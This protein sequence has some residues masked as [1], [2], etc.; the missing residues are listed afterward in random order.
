MTAGDVSAWDDLFAKELIPTVLGLVLDAW[1]QI[2][3]P[4]DDEHE[5]ETSTHLYCAMLTGKDRNRHPFLIQI[6][7]VE[8]D[9]DLMKISGRKDIAFFPSLNDEDIYFCLEAKRLNAVVGGVSKSLADEYVKNGMQRFVDAK[10]SKFVR[11]GGML[12]YVLDGDVGRAMKNVAKNI[13]ANHQALLM[14]PPGTWMPSSTRPSDPHTKESGHHRAR[15][16]VVF[17]I[18]HLFVAK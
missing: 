15:E 8:V 11:H 18:H 6:Q 7:D 12:G 17:R 3:K 9:M 2:Q 5:D 14:D 16:S 13:S 1:A 10:Y 4:T